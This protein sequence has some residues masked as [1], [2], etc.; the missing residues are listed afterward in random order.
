MLLHPPTN[1]ATCFSTVAHSNRPPSPTYSPQNSVGG[2]GSF[3]Q[4]FL[5]DEGLL[6]CGRLRLR[7]MILP[8]KFLEAG[9]Q[10]DQYDQAGLAARHIVEKAGTLLQGV[11]ERQELQQQAV[12]AA[13]KKEVVGARGGAG[14]QVLP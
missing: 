4:Q 3:V 11:K 10:S 1:L 8:D 12:A 9:P 7:S 5:L 2:F 13:S 14:F 6:D